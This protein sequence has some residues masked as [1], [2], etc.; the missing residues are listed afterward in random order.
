MANPKLNIHGSYATISLN[1]TIYLSQGGNYF[2]VNFNYVGTTLPAQFIGM[3]AMTKSGAFT[4]SD[5][6]NGQ[7]AL[8]RD[9]VGATTKLYYNNGGT[10]QSVALT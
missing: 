2:D 4:A 10:L 8:G 1:N 5:I 6:P 7:F 9:T 3:A